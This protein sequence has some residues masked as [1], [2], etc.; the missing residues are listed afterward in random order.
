MNGLDNPHLRTDG[1]CVYIIRPQQVTRSGSAIRAG[2]IYLSGA[3]ACVVLGLYWKQ[4]NTA[5]AVA[6][7]L[8]GMLFPIANLYLQDHLEQLPAWVRQGALEQWLTNGWYAGM[9]AFALALLA[10]VV[11]S[12]ATARWLAPQVLFAQAHS[13]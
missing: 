8:V 1:L 11:T 4:A 6:A 7:T 12:L 13:R 9:L 2:T 3:L 5:G 10:M